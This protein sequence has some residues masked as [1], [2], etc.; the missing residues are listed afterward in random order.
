MQSRKRFPVHAS[1]AEDTFVDF[2]YWKLPL[3]DLDLE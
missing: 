1:H 2:N 3:P